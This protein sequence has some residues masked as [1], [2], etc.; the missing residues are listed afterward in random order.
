MWHWS[1]GA[2]NCPGRRD[3]PW[4]M[5]VERCRLA[6]DRADRE[7]EEAGADALVVPGVLILAAVAVLFGV[8]HWAALVSVPALGWVVWRD[9]L[10]QKKRANGGPDR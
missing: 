9:K 7:I 4:C 1:C 6:C 8:E 5:R 10:R 2:I 3:C